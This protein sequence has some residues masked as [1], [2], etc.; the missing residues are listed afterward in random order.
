MCIR[1]RNDG[2]IKTE[3]V[4]RKNAEETLA[5]VY[6]G[7]I[8]SKMAE[9]APLLRYFHSAY[10]LE[11]NAE[12]RRIYRAEAYCPLYTDATGNIK[13]MKVQKHGFKQ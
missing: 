3:S 10:A 2:I 12:N 5:S 4:G 8:R 13:N 6:Q 9:F 11:D 1:D 7:T